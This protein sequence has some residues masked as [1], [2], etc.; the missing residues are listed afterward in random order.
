MTAVDSGRR[1]GRGAKPD[2]SEGSGEKKNK[3]HRMVHYIPMAY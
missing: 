3:H 2:W 1:E